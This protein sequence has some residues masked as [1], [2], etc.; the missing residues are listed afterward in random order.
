LEL[1]TTST[2]RRT[3]LFQRGPF[4][5][6]FIEVMVQLGQETGPPLIGLVLMPGCFYRHL[7]QQM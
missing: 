2:H 4:R 7:C 3:K 5:R 6:D 1:I